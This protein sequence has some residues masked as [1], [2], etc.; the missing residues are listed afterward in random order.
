MAAEVDVPPVRLRPGR[1][2]VEALDVGEDLAREERLPN[3]FDPLA[4]AVGA[5]RAV[6]REGAVV[7]AA[8]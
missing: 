3:R 7:P 6:A 2:L 5:Y 1:D 8:R 4:E